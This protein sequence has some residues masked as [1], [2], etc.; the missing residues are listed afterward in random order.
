MDNIN[1]LIAQNLFDGDTSVDYCTRRGFEA[2]DDYIE[3]H[4][5]RWIIVKNPNLI[6]HGRQYNFYI[7]D[8]TED[9]GVSIEGKAWDN[10]RYIAGCKSVLDLLGLEV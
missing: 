8:D 3:E 10:D 2:V 9:N 1:E 5:W 4:K 6:I 7:F